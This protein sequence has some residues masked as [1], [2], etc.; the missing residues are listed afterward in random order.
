MK[1]INKYYKKTT[2]SFSALVLISCLS[3]AALSQ[4]TPDDITDLVLVTGQSNVTGSLTDFD[5]GLDAVDGRVFAFTSSGSWQVANLNQAWDVDGWHPGNGSLTDPTRSPYNHFGFHFAKTVVSQDPNKVVGIIVASAPGEGIEH[6]DTT[7]AFFQQISTKV[8][9]ALNALSGAAQLNGILWHQG[10]TDWQYY[11]SS[12]QD[13]SSAQQSD[14]FYYP[15]RLDQLINNFRN[16]SWF[17]A[18]KPFICGETKR[19]RVNGRLNALNNDSSSWTGCVVASDLCTREN[20]TANCEV[21]SNLGTHFDA[22]GLRKLGDRYGRAYLS[23]L[24]SG[25]PQTCNGL[26]VTVDLNLGEST[27][28]GDDVVMGTP[29]SDDIRG[30]AGDDTICGMGGN[31]FIHGNSG[32]DWIDGGA[33]IDN[34]RGGQGSDTLYAGIGATSGTASRVFGGY[35]NDYIYGGPDADDL[36]GGRGS[37]TILGGAGGDELF[38][39]ED[40]DALFGQD[41][42]DSLKGGN[43]ENDALYGGPGNDLQTGGS[44]NN[45]YCGGGG[46]AGDN[47]IDCEVF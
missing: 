28:P 31:D 6:W 23:M 1:L 16:Q 43:G 36:R 10:E 20:P 45:D 40:D 11:G 2:R 41:G 13:L 33:G 29:G 38:G 9:D 14:G 39:N 44:G 24:N 47:S 46:D 7:G 12:D 26:A 17:G 32:D 3:N 22:T 25:N 37:D 21:W 30:K 8:N 5:L 15:D 34:I 4:I 35:G 18:A 42:N 27:T 19:A